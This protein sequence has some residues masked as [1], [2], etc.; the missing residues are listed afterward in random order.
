MLKKKDGERNLHFASCPHEVQ[1]APRERRDV[2]NGKKWTSFNAGVSLTDEEVRQLTDAACEIYPMQWVDTDKNAHP[3]RDKDYV[4][5][6]AKYKS[7]LVGCGNFETM[8]GRRTDS[9]AGD[10][11]FAQYR[12][13][14][15]RTG[16][17]SI[18]SCDFTNGYF[19]GPENSSN[20]AV[21]YSG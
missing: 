12:L 8:E 9:A 20:L 10:V 5:V 11:D 17:V 6:P 3:R 21:S 7:R 16:H 15:V 1:A 18:H 13:Q 2:S 14:L 19:Q 4:S